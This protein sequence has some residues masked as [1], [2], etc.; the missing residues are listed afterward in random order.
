MIKNLFR[1]KKTS[2]AEKA[3]PVAAHIDEDETIVINLSGSAE[4]ELPKVVLETE[5][6]KMDAPMSSPT[7]SASTSD[8]QDETVV[9]IPDGQEKEAEAINVV[10]GEP[11]TATQVNHVAGWISVSTGPQTG[12]NYSVSLGRNTIGRGPDNE[13]FLDVGDDMIAR[14]NHLSIAADPIT[15]KFYAVPG[16]A[17]NLAYLNDQPVLAAAEIS[18]KDRIQLGVTEFIFVQFFGNY[19]DWN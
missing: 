9:F 4:P 19:V 16:D 5:D 17:R 10:S 6:V 8:A 11:E 3:G 1:G 18:D 12:R 14:V 13:I 15:K 2:E 7:N